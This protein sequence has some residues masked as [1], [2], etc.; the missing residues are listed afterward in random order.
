M[1]REVAD[2]RV[3]A[4]AELAGVELP[5]AGECLDQRGLA[6]AVGAHQRDMLAALEPQLDVAQQRAAGDADLALLHLQH[7]ATAA[8]RRLESEAQRLAVAGIARDPLGLRELL[9]ARLGLSRARA[10]AEAVDEAFEAGDLGFL[11]LDRAPERE[12]ARSLLLA[13]GVP[14]AV[15]EPAAAAFQLE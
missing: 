9:G 10:R 4:A 8:L 14:R 5:V 6:A 12:L 15:E 13:P 2:L 1:L 11:A 3:V 7:H